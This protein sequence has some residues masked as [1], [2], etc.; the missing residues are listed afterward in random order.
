M[1]DV[2]NARDWRDVADEVESEVRIERGIV[3]IPRTHHEEH[4]AI[5]DRTHDRLGRDIAA[6]AWPAFDDERLTE[7]FRQPLSDEAPHDTGLA[8]AAKPDHDT[9][10]LRRIGLR[11]S[12]AR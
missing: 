12:D 6:R 1:R 9:H 4:V 2:P 7:S 3:R 11:A 8:T 10:R 5:R